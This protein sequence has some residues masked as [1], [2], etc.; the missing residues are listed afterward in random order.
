MVDDGT[1]AN[2]AAGT[3]FLSR[4]CDDITTLGARSQQTVIR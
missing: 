4:S 2:D 3:T 1:C